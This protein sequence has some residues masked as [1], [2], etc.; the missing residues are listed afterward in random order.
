M[1]VPKTDLPPVR[2]CLFDMDGLL[3]DTEDKYTLITNAV[4]ARYDHGP[5]P[6]SIKAQMQGRPGP[7]A[8]KILH[9]W[10]QL[11]ITPEQ[12]AAECAVLQKQYFPQS[13]PLPGVEKLLADL[14]GA[15]TITGEKVHIALATSSHEVNFKLKT[16][17]LKNLFEVFT[18]DRRVLGDDVRIPKGRGKPAPDIYLLA[19]KTI[20]ESLAEGEKEIKLE[21]CLVFEDSVP[22]I[23]AGRRAGMRCVWVPHPGLGE[24]YKGR[25][26]A[27]LAA[28]TGEGC[29]EDIDQLGAEGN[30]WADHLQSLE[31]FPYEKFGMVVEAKHHSCMARGIQ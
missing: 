5:L 10:A 14:E 30:G 9:E 25:E 2:A 15:K 11:P 23:E 21:E 26:A 18:N 29:A 31:A 24:E 8:S 13:L 16:G 27:V 17:H 1:A 28:R 7:S 4:L 12:Y 3:L 6:W 20:N 22:G 19:L